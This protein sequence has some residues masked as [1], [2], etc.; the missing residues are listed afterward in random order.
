MKQLTS[1][2]IRQMYID[3]FKEKGHRVEPSVSLVPKDDPSLLWINSGVATLKKYFDGR[4]IPENPRMVNAQKAIRTNDIENV[5]YTARHHTFFEMLGNFSIGDYFKKEAIEWAWEFLT[6]EKWLNLN[7]ELLS[8]TVHPEDDEAYDFWL[9]DIKLP[10]ERIIRIEE[11]FWDIGE[12][13]SGPNTEIFYD[14]GEEFG[15]DPN[16]PELYPG[17]ENNRYLEIWNLV[18]SQFNHNPDHTYTPLPKKNIDTGMGLERVTSVIQNTPTNFE[19]DLFLPIIRKTEELATTTYG[20][21]MEGDTAFK[22]IADHI[23]TV[24]FAVGDGALPSNEGRGYVLRRLI[25]RAVR[26]AKEIGINKP[27]MYE[28]VETVGEI[29]K[30][31]YPEVLKQK[32]FIGSVVKVEEERFH[33]TLNDGLEILTTII[34]K[35]KANGSKVF[36]GEE[37]FRLY[38]TYG[39]PKELTEEYVEEHGFSIDEAGY[40]KEMEKQRSRARNARQKVDSMQVQDT[41]LSEIEVDSEFIG[42]DNLEIDTKVVALFDGSEMINTAKTGDTVFLFLNK[43]P[44]YAESGGQVADKGWIYTD[45]AS[46]LVEDVQKSPKGQNIHRV[47]VKDGELNINDTVKAAVDSKFRNS[48]IKNHSATHLLHQAL[49]DVLGSHVNQAGSLVTPERL[50]F[51]F[52]HFNPLSDEELRKVEEIVNEKIWEAIPVEISLKKLQKAKEMGAMALF[53]EKYGDIVRVV[54]MG[55]FSLELCGGCHVKNTSE[56]GLFKLVSESGIGA[57]TRRIEAVTSKEAYQYLNGK[58]NILH[59]SANLFKSNEESLPERIEN[60]FHEMKQ[61]QKEN[62]SLSAKLANAESSQV[63]EQVE[64]IEGVTLLAQQVHV[65]DMNQLRNMIDD[66]KQKLGSCIILLATEN[67]GK[68]QLAS[69]VS[70]DLVEKGFHAGKL[71]KQAAQIC[72]GGGGG[73]PDMA[74]AG[75][76][77]PAKILEAVQSAKDYVLETIK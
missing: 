6:D 45:N 46:A 35:E 74:Q 42:Y 75:G 3:F 32:E 59:T 29:M 57:G 50:R 49:K 62:E 76:K 66:L 4:V 43:T 28:L 53:G 8:V 11:N 41:V 14:R 12:G 7:P 72:G 61:L 48:I 16:D 31:F 69:G 55:D 51:D 34:E 13:P 73:R 40:N 20:K 33:E 71:I 18:F 70:K 67:N 15:N 2:E 68:V 63:M 30:D 19:T 36:P 77:D 64:T 27:F 44:F 22:V 9:N 1:A 60:M 25:R 5:G 38:D 39:F 24:S 52:S 21:S 65:R 37:V 17:G 58:L 47:I 54:Q 10:K 23:R 56:I 26:F